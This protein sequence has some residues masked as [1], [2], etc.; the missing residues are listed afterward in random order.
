MNNQLV[1]RSEALPVAQAAES[2][3]ILQVIQRAAADPQ[4]DIE[5]MERL[6]AMH[7]RMQ[8][9]SA[10]QAFN[11]AMAS[12]QCDIPTVGEGAQNAHTKNNYATLDDINVVLKPIMQRHGFAITF[13]V[14]HQASGISVTGILMHSAGHR[15]QTTLLLPIDTGPGRNAVQAVGS[16]TTYGKRYVMC[17]LLNITTGD[18]RDDDGVC[19]EQYP[20]V[21][22]VQAKQ[23]ASLLAKCS[24]K[25]QAAFAAM[26]GSPESVYKHEFDRVLAMLSKSAK[27]AEA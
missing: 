22:A 20:P 24:D 18:A 19:A 13:K 5:K 21:T 14:D 7:E 1:E 26:H 16:S 6:M 27:A 4:C 12:M 17:A 11:A 25:A 3:T 23:L 8:Q 15:E 10:E 9:K 2:T